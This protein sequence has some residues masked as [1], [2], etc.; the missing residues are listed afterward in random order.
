M[1]T[2]PSPTGT[3]VLALCQ[4]EALQRRAKQSI[5][6]IERLQFENEKLKREV[7]ELRQARRDETPNL[8]AQLDQLFR[9]DAEKQAEIDELKLKL[10]L[11]QAR[12]RKWRLQNHCISSPTISSDEPE[13]STPA[14]VSRKRPRSENPDAQRPLRE[15]SANAAPSH[16]PPRSKRLSDR[17]ADAIPAVAEDGEDY[18]RSRSDITTGQVFEDDQANC[19]RHR[20]QALLSAPAPV[21]PLLPRPDRSFSTASTAPSRVQEKTSSPL[22][23]A[24]EAN[25]AGNGSARLQRLPGRSKKPVAPEDDEPFRA[26]PVSRLNRSHFRIN[27]MYTG[28]YDYAY[29][30]N[31]CGREARMGHSGCTRAECCGD[32]FKALA[33]TLPVENDISEDDLLLEFLGPGSEANIQ[34]LTPLAREK[35]IHEARSKRLANLYG[36]MHR[37]AFNR[38]QSPPGYWDTDMPGTQEEQHNREKARLGERE[39][40][41][42]RYQDAM[43]GNGRWLFADE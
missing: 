28:G 17:G 33:A 14:S 39:E 19:P 15:I 26:R 23:P 37:A 18:H 3:L 40:V 13:A 9:Q 30:E 42:S 29:D 34:A 11:I 7:K 2:L 1:S 35:L 38:P 21:T 5:E 12:E 25:P 16:P 31:F 20:L 41:E 24:A 22:Q 32:K 4:T 27:P 6:T 10:R 36:K 8:S 43:K